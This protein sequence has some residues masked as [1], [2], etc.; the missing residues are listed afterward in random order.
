M[1]H[2]CGHGFIKACQKCFDEKMGV[3]QDRIKTLEKAL[4]EL[5]ELKIVKDVQG[6]VPWYRERK[7]PAWA[8]AFACFPEY[9][10]EEALNG[11]ETS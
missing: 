2:Y 5:C 4:H 9:A 3:A 11:A 6:D 8:S 7:G 10:K 1:S